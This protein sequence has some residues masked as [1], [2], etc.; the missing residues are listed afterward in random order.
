MHHVDG[1]YIPSVSKDPQ[2]FCQ[3]SDLC[4]NCQEK[5]TPSDCVFEDLA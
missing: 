2:N 1:K 3:A 5:S 4:F